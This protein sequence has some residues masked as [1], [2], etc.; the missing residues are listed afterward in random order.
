MPY[1]LVYV[2]LIATSTY[3]LQL[4]IRDQLQLYIHPRYILFTVSM[5]LIGFVLAILGFYANKSKL[6][7]RS[8]IGY[9]PLIIMVALALVFA[10]RSLSS[11]TVSQRSTGVDP[12]AVGEQTLDYYSGS[13]KNLELIDWARLIS[14]NS[15]PEYYTNR[16]LSVS[17]FIYDTGNSD[18]FQVARFV[19]TCCAVDAQPTGIDVFY[20]NWRAEFE[21]DQWVQIEGGVA[22]KQI[23]STNKLVVIPESI[24]PIEEPDNP[25]AN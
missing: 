18:T 11:F 1:K 4:A 17:G 24:Q 2:L 20:P 12:F 7:W 6:P 13:S 3:I 9:M 15:N 22:E 16:E 21:Q 19:V 25:Y 14:R 8:L 23:N 10:P 5:S